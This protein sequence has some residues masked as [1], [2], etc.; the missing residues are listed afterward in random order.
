MFA[1]GDD[2]NPLAMLGYEE[3][4]LA[5]DGTTTTTYV[6]DAVGFDLRMRFDGRDI[7]SL[8]VELGADGIPLALFGAIR[9]AEP[10]PDALLGFADGVTLKRARLR[11]EDNSLTERLLSLIAEVDDSDVETI[12]GQTVED[13]EAQLEDVLNLELARQVS[14]A[15]TAYLNDPRSITFAI[16]PELPVS[17]QRIMAGTEDPAVLIELLQMSVTA[18]D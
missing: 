2:E 16:A 9:T 8:I 15:L 11:F 13:I 1:D 10:D 7:G 5:F 6:D 14:A 4:N 3:L 18:N 12:V 17:F